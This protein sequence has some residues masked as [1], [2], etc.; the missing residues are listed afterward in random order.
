MGSSV[1]YQ[2]AHNRKA[3]DSISINSIENKYKLDSICSNTDN[4]NINQSSIIQSDTRENT[5]ISEI[6]E[7]TIPYK[8]IWN[9]GGKS[10]KISG[11][12]LDDWK[13][14]MELQKNI[15]SG[16][17]EIIIDLTRSK[18]EFKFIVDNKWL[19]SQSYDIIKDKNNYNNVIDLTNYSPNTDDYQGINENEQRNKRKRKLSMEYGS[20]YVKKSDFEREVPSLPIY[21]R[22]CFDLN[23]RIE[24][25][26]IRKQS[27]SFLNQNL[28][29]NILENKAYKTILNIS[30]EKLSHVY[31][32]I[33]SNSYIINQNQY[34]KSA[35]TQ[36]INHKFLTFVY[37]TP[38]K[39]E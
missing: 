33:D 28:N 21:F 24:P 38:I 18:H 32:D 4:I 19:C 12:F 39:E 34:L 8:F 35:I 26:N 37:Y 14:E 6:K 29:K 36:R 3:N 10:V 5:K 1:E 2:K 7:V 17:F 25:K 16:L 11:T 20:I 27:H 13:K 15:K 9:N 30:H 22:K 31:Y 23:E